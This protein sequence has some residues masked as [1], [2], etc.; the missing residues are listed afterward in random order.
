MA[1][2]TR[3]FIEIS[4]ATNF[5]INTASLIISVVTVNLSGSQVWSAKIHNLFAGLFGHGIDNVVLRC[6]LTWM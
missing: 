2:S 5:L 4:A 3:R 6:Q 1:V